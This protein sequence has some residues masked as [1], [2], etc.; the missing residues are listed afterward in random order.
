MVQHLNRGSRGRFRC[1][2]IMKGARVEVGLGRVQRGEGLKGYGGAG[3]LGCE[4]RGCG[5]RGGCKRC[6]INTPITWQFGCRRGGAAGAPPNTPSPPPSYSPHH[7]HHIPSHDGINSDLM[8]SSSLR[9]TLARASC[10][11]LRM[12]VTP[13]RGIKNTF[14]NA[15]QMLEMLLA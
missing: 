11:R 5:V 7:P 3:V 6:P 2:E 14:L 10:Q 1:V 9:Q 8:A 13:G 15:I 4:V 12:N